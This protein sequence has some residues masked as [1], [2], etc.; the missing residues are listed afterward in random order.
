MHV[1]DC[2]SEFTTRLSDVAVLSLPN[3]GF[4]LYGSFWSNMV[5]VRPCCKIGF[6]LFSGNENE[7]LPDLKTTSHHKNPTN[8]K[9]PTTLRPHHHGGTPIQSPSTALARRAVVLERPTFP[10]PSTTPSSF[11]QHPYH[12]QCFYRRNSF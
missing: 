7:W 10:D 5:I 9:R 1:H 12:H 3:T 6:S 4:H 8:C 11:G 2:N